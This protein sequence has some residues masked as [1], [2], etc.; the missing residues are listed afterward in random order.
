MKKSVASEEI[1]NI[2]RPLLDTGE[3]TAESEQVYHYV[4]SLWA[5]CQTVKW[6]ATMFVSH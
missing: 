6:L 3:E 1:A 5:S 2:G 4:S